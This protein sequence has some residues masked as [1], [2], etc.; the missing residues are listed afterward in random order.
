MSFQKSQPRPLFSWK[1]LEKYRETIHELAHL[2]VAKDA[3]LN[4][5]CI[6]KGYS[7]VAGMGMAVDTIRDPN[8]LYEGFRFDSSL[9]YKNAQH[10]F[11]SSVA[12]EVGMLS[13]KLRDLEQELVK[14][15]NMDSDFIRMEY[16]PILDPSEKEKTLCLNNVA[17][18]FRKY[19]HRVYVSE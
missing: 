12:H 4:T 13:R 7:D 18:S 2:L 19:Y 1:G 15:Y 17:R 16:A 6:A 11:V 14:D 9:T 10:Y 5:L 3:E 8:I